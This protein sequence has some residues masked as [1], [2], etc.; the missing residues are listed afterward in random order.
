MVGEKIKY[1]IN[2][3]S[4][5]IEVSKFIDDYHCNNLHYKHPEK[6]PNFVKTKMNG[7][8]TLYNKDKEP[9]YIGK[10]NNCIRSRLASHL[11]TE[12]RTCND[13]DNL[14]VK[15]KRTEY[16]YFSYIQ[17][18][19][20]TT[21]FLEVYLI[22]KYKPKFNIEFNP[23]F[24]YPDRWYVFL[25]KNKTQKMINEEKA[26]FELMKSFNYEI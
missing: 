15:Y 12:P 23:N 1:T 4:G 10:S 18:E 17:T 5:I 8:Y 16:K 6:K 21:S 7:I 19:K 9:I 20:I 13:I 3:F 26:I 11:I 25:D 2:N 14:F 22:E 24:K